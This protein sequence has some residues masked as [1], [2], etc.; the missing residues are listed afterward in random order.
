MKTHKELVKKMLK[1]PAVR[2][3]YEA[4]KEEFALLD[5]LLRARR[6][7]GLTQ[8]EVNLDYTDVRSPIDGRIG[9]TA[10]TIGNLV[11]PASGVLATIVHVPDMQ[12]ICSNKPFLAMG[13]RRGTIASRL[14]T[15]QRRS[16][17]ALQSSPHITK[18]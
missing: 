13:A 11:N 9:R 8:A 10:Y 17:T 6:R 12:A 15:S 16:S 7:A 2:A 3:E 1:N 4:Q 14:S 18:P 5:E